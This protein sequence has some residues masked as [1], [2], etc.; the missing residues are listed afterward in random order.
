MHCGLDMQNN[1]IQSRK[2]IS[3]R[4]CKQALRRGEDKCW[5]TKAAQMVEQV[6][7]KERRYRNRTVQLQ[8][9]FTLTDTI[10]FLCFC[11]A[12]A[13]LLQLA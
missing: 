11:V 4:Q 7:K 8:H 10:A 3:Q 2:D 5:N 9:T 6:S 12:C 13:S 1:S